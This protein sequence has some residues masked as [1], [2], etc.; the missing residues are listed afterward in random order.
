MPKQQGQFITIAP[1]AG[2]T[3]NGVGY[4]V[5]V[6][7]IV[8]PNG[9]DKGIDEITRALV[10]DLQQNSDLHPAGDAQP[11]TVGGTAGRS[12]TLY[13][14]SPFA[15]ADGSPQKERDWLVTVLQPDGSVLFLIFVAPQIH[16]PRFQPS[17]EAMLD[18]VRF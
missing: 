14:T 10:Q 7:G 1:K 18:S 9:E 17:F 6:N 12:V 4:G 11:I 2:V 13:S 8:P 5:V 15:A 16:F 3:S